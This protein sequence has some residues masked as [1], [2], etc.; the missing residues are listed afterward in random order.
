MKN[1]LVIAILLSVSLTF[2][3]QVE[4]KF[5]KQGT[6]TEATYYYDNGIVAQ[7]GFFNKEN[8]LEGTWTSFDNE[9]NKIATGNY[10]SGVKVGKWFFWNK[11]TLT[12]VDYVN[13]SIENV[14][15]WQNKSS[16]A[17]R[18]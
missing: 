4:P 13:N 10:N 11:K 1:I 8:K 6:K 12:E 5:E 15:E 16:L 18:D 17:V 9:G 2:A 7:N 14:S 3:Q